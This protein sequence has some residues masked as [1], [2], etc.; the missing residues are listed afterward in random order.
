MAGGAFSRVVATP[1][2]APMDPAD[3]HPV[4]HVKDGLG[5]SVLVFIDLHDQLPALPHG[6]GERGQRQAGEPPELCGRA[7]VAA[8]RYRHLFCTFMHGLADERAVAAKEPVL[9]RLEIVSSLAVTSGMN[10]AKDR[11]K[12]RDVVGRVVGAVERGGF[13]R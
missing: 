5:R 7:A 3:R 6:G 4:W 2:L 13:G 10:V 8:A 11:L 1:L 9:A 12:N